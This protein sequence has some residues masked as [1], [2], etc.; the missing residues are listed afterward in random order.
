M[1]SFLQKLEMFHFFK[2][3]NISN[4][5]FTEFS[6][7]LYPPSPFWALTCTPETEMGDL[8]SR[9]PGNPYPRSRLRGAE[10]TTEV[11]RDPPAL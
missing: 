7:I 9:P 6:N 8:S 10:Q 3:Q 4:G 2:F 5:K 1:P 11:T